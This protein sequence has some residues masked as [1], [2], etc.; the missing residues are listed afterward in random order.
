[1]QAIKKLYLEDHILGAFW[2]LS[3]L[4]MRMSLRA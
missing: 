2:G 3:G 4:R 1:M